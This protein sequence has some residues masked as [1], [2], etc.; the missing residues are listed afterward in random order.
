MPIYRIFIFC[1][2]LSCTPP[3][4]DIESYHQV[5]VYIDN[6][7]FGIFSLIG[8]DPQQQQ[9]M[10]ITLSREFLFQRSLFKWVR[11]EKKL[12]MEPRSIVLGKHGILLGCQP[13]SW[14]IQSLPLGG[15]FESVSF[16]CLGYTN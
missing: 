9:Y 15:Y 3:I 1:M 7:D 14:M 5:H 12:K 13:I 2:V 6:L 10:T 4:A 11:E 16:T 8:N